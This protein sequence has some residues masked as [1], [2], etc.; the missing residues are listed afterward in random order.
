M[1]SLRRCKIRRWYNVKNAR[2][3]RHKR[4]PFCWLNTTKGVMYSHSACCSR[5]EK[6]IR[7]GPSRCNIRACTPCWS[8]PRSPCLEPC[9][10]SVGTTLSATSVHRCLYQPHH[11]PIRAECSEVGAQVQLL[12]V[13]PNSMVF[14]CHLA[15]CAAREAWS[16]EETRASLPRGTA[17]RNGGL[18]SASE[19]AGPGPLILTI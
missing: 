16:R 8:Q 19:S 3:P 1:W 9:E 13:S 11:V 10:S 17:T 2:H 18:A 12:R 7:R 15:R 14:E 6:R 4:Y 5:A